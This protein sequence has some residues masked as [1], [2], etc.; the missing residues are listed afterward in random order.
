MGERRTDNTSPY[1]PH[2]YEDLTARS[3]SNTPTE[4]RPSSELETE[5]RQ[6]RSP[7]SS[8][9]VNFT[10]N[11]NTERGHSST[12]DY[13]GN[14]TKSVVRD[15]NQQAEGSSGNISERKESSGST[16]R[17]SDKTERHSHSQDKTMSSP[18]GRQSG[19]SRTGSEGSNVK[20]S[21]QTSEGGKGEGKKEQQ[22]SGPKSSRLVS[23]V[24]VRY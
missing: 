18:S 17:M 20:T 4:Q 3:T 21:R 19:T 14:T 13:F 1:N 8:D 5:S 16:A 2:P 23:G 22:T 10:S 9:L 12:F 11:H 15:L 24:F 7:L 6:R